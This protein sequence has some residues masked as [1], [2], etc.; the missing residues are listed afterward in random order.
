MSGGE[1]VPPGRSWRDTCFLRGIGGRPS[2]SGAT[3]TRGESGTNMMYMNSATFRTPK[4]A[5]LSEERSTSL[6]MF[7]ARFPF[8]PSRTEVIDA[9]TAFLSRVSCRMAAMEDPMCFKR[10]ARTLTLRRFD[11]SCASPSCDTVLHHGRDEGR[12]DSLHQHDFRVSLRA[13]QID[14]DIVAVPLEFNVDH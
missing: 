1:Y 10:Q 12:C 11:S 13:Q 9:G 5:S 7:I 6:K 2:P 8:F 14:G 4:K 3:P